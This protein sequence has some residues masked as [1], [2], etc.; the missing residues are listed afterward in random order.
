MVTGL[1]DVIAYLDK[2][3]IS[4]RSKAEHLKRL[5]QTFTQSSLIG[6]WFRIETCF[7]QHRL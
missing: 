3:L 6:F 1:P 4:T 7:L 5:C 2:I